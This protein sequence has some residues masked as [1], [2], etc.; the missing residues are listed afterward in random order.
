MVVA[1]ALWMIGLSGGIGGPGKG[2]EP[3]DILIDLNGSG[4]AGQPAQGA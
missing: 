2:I 4:A 3:R 1:P